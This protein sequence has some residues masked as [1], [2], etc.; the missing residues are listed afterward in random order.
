ML[1]G[2]AESSGMVLTNVAMSY[3]ED[4][5]SLLAIVHLFRIDIVSQ[6][7]PSNL[8]ALDDRP[9][10]TMYEGIYDGIGDFQCFMLFPGIFGEF[11]GSVLSQLDF[12]R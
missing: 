2:T 12:S 10:V 8:T 11:P 5:G 9:L 4:N 1:D 3:G 6:I 7:T